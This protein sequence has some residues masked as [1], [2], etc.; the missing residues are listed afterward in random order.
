[1]RNM[2]MT[3][4][5]DDWRPEEEKKPYPICEDL[6]KVLNG[7]VNPAGEEDITIGDVENLINHSLDT[8]ELAFKAYLFGYTRGLQA[9]RD[10]T[11]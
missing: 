6:Q 9:G 8:T 3:N 10:R 7:E 11:W 1:M 5:A 2:N 4:T